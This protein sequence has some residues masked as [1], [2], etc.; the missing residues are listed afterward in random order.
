MKMVSTSIM[1]HWEF[2]LRSNLSGMPLC[3]ILHGYTTV[4][5]LVLV[6][7][8]VYRTY[9]MLPRCTVPTVCSPGVQY[10]CMLPRCTVL[11][12]A[13]Q[14]YSRPL[15]AAFC[16]RVQSTCLY[17]TCTCCIVSWCTVNSTT[18]AIFCLGV[19]RCTIHAVFCTGV[20]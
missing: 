11:L 16:P 8:K 1:A 18:P 6:Y 13:P 2:R 3:L 5:C 20:P 10:Y 9:C 15:P 19:V 7:Y 12:Y 14:V 4:F 17:Y